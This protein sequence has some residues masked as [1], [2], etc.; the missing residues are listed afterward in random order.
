VIDVIEELRKY[1]LHIDVYD[2]WANA[3]EVYNEFGLPLL[4][5]PSQL[6][7]NYEA[8]VLAVGH[9]EF[10]NFNFENHLASPSVVFDVKS[11]LPKDKVDGCL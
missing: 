11:F 2:P 10:A 1:N 6:K 4:S 5:E 7:E 3:T 8:V 9:K